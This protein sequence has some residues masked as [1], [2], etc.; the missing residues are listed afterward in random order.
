M[1]AGAATVKTAP[2]RWRVAK[3]V[4]RMDSRPPAARDRMSGWTDT[5]A[6]GPCPTSPGSSPKARPIPGFTCPQHSCSGPFM[7]LN[8]GMPGRSW[9][10]VSSRC[11]APTDICR[12]YSGCRVRPVEIVWFGFTGGLIPCFSAIAVL[13][14]A[15]K[16]HAVALGAVMVGAFGLG[17]AATLSVSGWPPPGAPA[18]SPDGRGWQ[19]GQ[20][21]C[22]GFRRASC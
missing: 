4:W 9:P 16:F 3:P 6:K 10:P 20:T 5:R 14:V 15:L 21:A 7:R 8:R 2:G 17:L 22:P 13:L 11:A 18:G 1:A 19:G 12:R